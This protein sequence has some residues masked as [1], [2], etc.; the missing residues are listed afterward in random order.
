MYIKQISYANLFLRT[1]F[2]IVFPF[3]NWFEIA[4]DTNVNRVCFCTAYN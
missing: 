2:M 1:D 4:S 3:A